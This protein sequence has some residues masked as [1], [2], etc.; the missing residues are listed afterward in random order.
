MSAHFFSFLLLT[1]DC[2]TVRRTFMKDMPSSTEGLRN[3]K[4][5]IH[6]YL[7]SDLSFLAYLFLF[8]DSLASFLVSIN[9]II[10]NFLFSQL[11]TP[12]HHH[13]AMLIANALVID[14]SQRSLYNACFNSKKFRLFNRDRGK[15]KKVICICEKAPFDVAFIDI[16]HLVLTTLNFSIC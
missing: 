2:F 1:K 13:A 14:E 12:S 15:W 16:D 8:K 3:L 5:E 11:P 4:P 10:F 6:Y 7:F 9:Q